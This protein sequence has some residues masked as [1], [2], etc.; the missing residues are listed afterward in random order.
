MKKS[1]IDE[2]DCIAKF[3]PEPGYSIMQTIP[4]FFIGT[5]IIAGAL[6]MNISYIGW[7]GILLWI[8]GLYRYYYIR[9]IKFF[10]TKEQIVVRKGILSIRTDYLELYRVRDIE[11]L[12]PLWIRLLGLMSIRLV[13]FDS[14]SQFLLL[15]GIKQ[16]D[17]ANVIRDNVQ[18][19]R[20]EN[21][22]LTMDRPYPGLNG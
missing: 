17:I 3:S 13:T 4:K 21:K 2:D 12:Q 5:I 8:Y 1:I 19:A 7:A 11:I 20:K 22:I 6:Y 10:L 16:S 18:S 9:N 15:K 14:S